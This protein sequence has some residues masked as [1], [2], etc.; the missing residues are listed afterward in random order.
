[1]SKA[2]LAETTRLLALH[3]AHYTQ[4]Y[5]NIPSLNVLELL[6]VVERTEQQTAL[7]HDSMEISGGLPRDRKTAGRG[8]E[9]ALTG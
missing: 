6:G 4:R 2:Q 1:M 8:A 5:G 7:L 3:L 9:K